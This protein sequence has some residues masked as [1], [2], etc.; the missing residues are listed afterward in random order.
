MIEVYG[1]LFNFPSPSVGAIVVT[2][3]DLVHPAD[4][5]H[6]RPYASMGAGVSRQARLRWPGVDEEL[7]ETILNG[8]QTGA[9]ML[10][11]TDEASCVVFHFLVKRV[12]HKTADLPT[13]AESA[14]QLRDYV[15]ELESDPDIDLGDILIPRPGCGAGGESWARVKPVLE[16]ILPEPRWWIIDRYEEETD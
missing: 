10:K 2:G 1:D 8:N 9:C 3:S 16:A 5:D 6:P 11:W 4:D 7:A 15:I 12:G 14:R 13:I